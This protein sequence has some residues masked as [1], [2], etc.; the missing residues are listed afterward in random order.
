MTLEWRRFVMFALI[1]ASGKQYPVQEGSVIQLDSYQGN[2]KDEVVFERVLFIR[3]QDQVVVGRPY[4]DGAKVKGI[5]LR[6]GK[7]K[8]VVVFKYKPK[9]KYRRLT[10]HRQPMT[11][12]KIQSIES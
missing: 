10:G 3:N 2:L 9:V 4:V 6:N 12:I 5:V 11:L 8:K 1:E 7:S